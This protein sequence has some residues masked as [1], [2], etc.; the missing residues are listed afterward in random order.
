VQAPPASPPDRV[1]GGTQ[2]RVRLR[3]CVG[4]RQTAAAS[5][6]VRLVL[7]EGQLV[8]PIGRGRPPGRG[9]WLHPAAACVASAARTR[10][11][12]RAFRAPVGRVDVEAVLAAITAA[13]SLAG[14]L[15]ASH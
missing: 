11:F 7:V 2:V 3:T 8:V 6:L 15:A 1:P 12:D 4:C 14:A 10:A 9:A 5:A 13:A